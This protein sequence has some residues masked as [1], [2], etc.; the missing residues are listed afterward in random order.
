MLGD[1]FHYVNALRIKEK[2]T[3]PFQDF[4]LCLQAYQS[5]LLKNSSKTDEKEPK[6][7]ENYTAKD[8][9][10]MRKDLQD[11]LEGKGFVQALSLIHI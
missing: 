8:L 3:G 6:A 1:S 10:K 4:L 7:E 5:A 2:K 9:L 11:Q